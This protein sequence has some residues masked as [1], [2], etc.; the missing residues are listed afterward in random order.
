MNQYEFLEHV[1]TRPGMYSGANSSTAVLAFLGGYGCTP[2]GSQL[3]SATAVSELLDSMRVHLARELGSDPACALALTDYVKRRSGG[4][5]VAGLAVLRD[6]LAAVRRRDDETAAA[7]SRHAETPHPRA[8]GAAA[9]S[10]AS[11]TEADLPVILSFIRALAE[12]E[13]LAHQ[14]V[15]TE[16]GL[17]E[18]LFGPRPYAEA[19]IARVGD[20]PVGQAIFF[21]NYSTFLA[22]PGIYIEDIF[23]LPEHR[24]LGAGKAL[25]TAVVRIA[26]ERCCARVEWSVLDWNEPAI[27]F[28]KRMGADVMADWR[29]CRL[30][31]H[32]IDKLADRG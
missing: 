3:P 13:R 20:T 29:I 12:Y 30:N 31:A 2:D 28:Y 17:R 24:G 22:R 26:K 23:V 10:I 6:A 15:A 9:I 18:T 11:A 19:L 7:G 16:A 4:D 25:L 1:L 21:H 14:C 27:E 8:D 32:G 5:D